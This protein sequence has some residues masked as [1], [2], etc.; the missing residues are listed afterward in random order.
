MPKLAAFPK[1][2]IKQL[3]SGQMSIFEWIKLADELRVDG[4]EFYNNFADVKDS[5]NWSTV[6]KAVEETGM[7]IPMMCASPDFTI[8]DPILRKQEVEKEIYAIEMSAAL[9]AKYCRVLS[10]Q[11]RKDI[12]REE[13]MNYVVDSINACIPTAE[14]LGIT[15]IIE[16]HYKD[17]FWTEPEFAQMMD[18]FVELVSRID[19]KSFGV[20]YD[21]SNVIA[22]GEEPLE[23]LEKIKHRVVTMHASDRYLANGTIEDLRKAEGGSA[24]YVSFFKHGVIGKG[25]NDYDAI[26]KTL[27]D[28]GFDSWI[29]IEDGVDGMDQMHESADFLRE[30]IKKYWPNY[31][32][33]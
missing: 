11:R 33:R 12:T 5:K 26:F 18:V 7:V 19:S 3:V 6:R 24:G 4:L 30:K 20:N 15:L 22:A 2:F 9:G 32:P 14:K 25:L 8:P 31:Q 23:L 1:G 29:S 17:D 16:N 10:G 28:V 13:G 21:P 27:K